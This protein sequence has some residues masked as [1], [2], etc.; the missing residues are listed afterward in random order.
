MEASFEGFSINNIPRLDNEHADI[1]AKSAA[2]GG[3]LYL[4]KYYSKY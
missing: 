3:S 1:L 4:P 2:Q